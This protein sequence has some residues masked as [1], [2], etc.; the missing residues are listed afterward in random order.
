MPVLSTIGLNGGRLS[1]DLYLLARVHAVAYSVEIDLIGIP[2]PLVNYG[3]LKLV[4]RFGGL[5]S[6]HRE[7]GN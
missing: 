6:W 4:G 2:I 7:L 1:K 5:C 3:L